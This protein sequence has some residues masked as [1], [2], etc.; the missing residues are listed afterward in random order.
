VAF[1]IDLCKIVSKNA[2]ENCFWR[3]CLFFVFKIVMVVVYNV[4]LLKCFNSFFLTLV[5]PIAAKVN[6]D[7]A[8]LVIPWSGIEYLILGIFGDFL[9][10]QNCEYL[11]RVIEH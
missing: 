5:I 3:M 6:P 4:L 10:A 7:P 1:K 9:S 8:L 2:F 11:L